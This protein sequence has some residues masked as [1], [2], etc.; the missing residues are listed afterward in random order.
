MRIAV[1]GSGPSAI[2]FVDYLT[3]RLRN[4]EI[5]VYERFPIPGGIPAIAIP[6]HRVK[7]ELLVNRWNEIC[8]NRNVDLVL[9]TLVTE[10]KLPE[11]NIWTSSNIV[12]FSKL[13]SKYDYVVIASGAWRSRKLGIP[14]EEFC[15][16][17]LKLLTNIKLCNYNIVKCVDVG[18]EVVV[19]GA[20]RTAVDVVD[21]LLRQGVKIYLVYRRSIVESRAYDLLKKF[22]NYVSIIEKS[23]TT[24]VMRLSLIH[25]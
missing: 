22:L 3:S 11:D 8:R 16:P 14:G 25:I 20:G 21:T 2:S 1:I 12:K 13:L 24:Q 18:D 23:T 4:V 6:K 15:I 7:L 17:A 5:D 10:D 9:N 19:I